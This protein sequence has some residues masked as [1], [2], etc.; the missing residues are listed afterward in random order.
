MR[1]QANEL[2]SGRMNH[3]HTQSGTVSVLVSRQQ[4]SGLPVHVEML[5]QMIV[6]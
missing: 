5:T 4:S 2:K 3:V 1:V 6:V